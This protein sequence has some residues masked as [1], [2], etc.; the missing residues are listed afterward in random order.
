VA[1]AALEVLR[2]EKL[3][4][5]AMVMGE[6]FRAGLRRIPS[7]G[8]VESV[9]GRGLLN[10]MVIEDRKGDGGPAWEICLELKEHGLLAKPTHGNI[11]R[12]APPLC[13]DT[14]QVDQA[15]GIVEASLKKF[16]H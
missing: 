7:R 14:A 15:L 3:A 11:I 10:A 2:D 13:I 4:D 12:M 9:R 8:L 6:R 1:T 5:N 16:M